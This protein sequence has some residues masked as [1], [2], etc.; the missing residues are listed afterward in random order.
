ML[1]GAKFKFEVWTD[2]KNLEY[3]MK[4]QKLNRKQACW[5]LYLPRF[6]FT[7]KHVPGSKMGKTDRLSRRL[8]WRVGIENDN[9]NQTLIKEQCIYSL[10]EVVI[11]GLEVEKI[12]KIKIARGKDKEVV[13][14]VEKI[15]KAEIKVLRGEE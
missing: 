6:D 2:Y 1:E 8:D 15:K 5:A 11:E 9:N 13:K 10:V 4:V 12:E 7:L 3:F 14:V